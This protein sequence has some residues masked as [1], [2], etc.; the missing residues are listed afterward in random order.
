MS[1]AQ[2]WED[3]ANAIVPIMSIPDTASVDERRIPASTGQIYVDPARYDSWNAL[4]SRTGAD[5]SYN[6]AVFLGILT[7]DQAL[8]CA[9][10]APIAGLPEWSRITSI[11]SGPNPIKWYDIVWKDPATGQLKM[12]IPPAVNPFNSHAYVLVYNRADGNLHTV[13]FGRNHEGKLILFDPQTP[14]DYIKGETEIEEYFRNQTGVTRAA[15]LGTQVRGLSSFGV[16]SLVPSM[17]L[18][19]RRIVDLNDE[20]L[21]SLMGLLVPRCFPEH[22]PL[23]DFNTY[24]AVYILDGSGKPIAMSLIRDDLSELSIWS[25][26][27]A[28]EHQ[29]RGLA[30]ILIGNFAI[31]ALRGIR[32][33]TTPVKLIS[34]SESF[35]TAMIDLEPQI[36]RNKLYESM[37]FHFPVGTFVDT[38]KPGNPS[39]K[40]T[41]YSANPAERKITYTTDLGTLATD[42]VIKCTSSAG[43]CPME[44]T[45]GEI[46]SFYR[47]GLGV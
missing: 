35:G 46:V 18:E 14:T 13:V 11:L 16:S 2:L 39:V 24:V 6:V 7:H 38:T 32:R 40:I 21:G 44:S 15:V 42:Q 34:T 1:S 45:L 27:V 43:G 36:I 23:R 8:E 5:C 20:F 25:I 12:S 9:S 31:S 37:G 19:C 10:R 22:P 30:K 17:S 3:D 4:I 41:S 28:P 47:R 33:L 29:G 26:C